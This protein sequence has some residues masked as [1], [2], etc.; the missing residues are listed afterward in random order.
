MRKIKFYLCVCMLS[1]YATF[2]FS[3]EQS[4]ENFLTKFLNT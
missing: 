2:L 1:Q 3:T 4:C